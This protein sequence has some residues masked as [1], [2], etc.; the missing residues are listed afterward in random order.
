M[1]GQPATAAAPHNLEH[2]PCGWAASHHSCSSQPRTQTVWMGSQPPQLLLITSNTDR[3]NGQPP[4]T[5]A[6]H[7]LHADK[8]R[9]PATPSDPQRVTVCNLSHFMTTW[10][11]ET[12]GGRRGGYCL[13]MSLTTSELKDSHGVGV[14]G[15]SGT[16]T[17][18]S[19]DPNSSR[20]LDGQPRINT[21]R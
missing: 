11:S 2:R 13:P 5:A 8:A 4:T 14:W 1:D 10:M 16:S 7:K 9:A 15:V 3:V 12:D 19:E 18:G 6:P 20:W 17:S 21:V